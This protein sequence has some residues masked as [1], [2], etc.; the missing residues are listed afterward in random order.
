MHYQ[1]RIQ[2]DID[3]VPPSYLLGDGGVARF[4]SI[5][6]AKWE[7]EKFAKSLEREVRDTNQ[8]D[9]VQI[10]EHVMARIRA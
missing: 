9:V 1:V 6:D 2:P 3:G 4:D 5:H 8:I 7:A 10:Q